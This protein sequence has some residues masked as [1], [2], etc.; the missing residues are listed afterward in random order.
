MK[1]SIKRSAKTLALLLAAAWLFLTLMGCGRAASASDEPQEEPSAASV[2]GPSAAPSAAAALPARSPGPEDTDASF[3]AALATAIR[4]NGESAAI[5]GPGASASGRV[6]TISAAGT[7]LLSGSL[8]DGQIVVDAG[9]EALVRLVLNGAEITNKSGAPIYAKG[10]K[11]L[12]LTLAEGTKNALTDG[13]AN[14]IYEN[15]D[16]EEPNAALFSKGDLSINGLGSLT[17]DAGFQNGVVSKDALL[18]ASGV[19]E[20]NALKH[21][22]RGNDSVEILGGE[23]AVQAGA[24]AIQTNNTADAEMGWLLIEGG[25]FELSAGNDGLQ[26][27]RALTIGGGSFRI[28]S[29]GAGQA[30]GGSS[31]ES[32]S[33]K[34]IKSGGDLVILGGSFEIDSQ[35]DALHTN[36]SAEISGGELSLRSG[37]DGIHADGDLRISG[38]SVTVLESYEGLEGSNVYISGGEISVVSSDDGINAAG[39][40]DGSGLGGR[41]GRDA[42][43]PGGA[44]GDHLL[45]ISGGAVRVQTRSDGLDSNGSIEI[46]G[47]L[48]ISEALPERDGDALD[49]GG[50]VKFTGGTIIYAGTLSTGVN[51]GADS[52]QSYVYASA[53]IAAGSE[54]SVRKDGKTLLAYTPSAS[55]RVMAF[56]CPEI[57]AG[58]SYEI[59]H[60]ETPLAT[61]TA[62]EG[63]GGM[64]GGQGGRGGAFPGGGAPEGGFPGG[65]QRPGRS[66]DGGAAP[67]SGGATP[68]A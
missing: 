55:I 11:K 27:D 68:V 3:D 54:I 14:F 7:Y 60:S 41:F 22:I 21:G 65:G 2:A 19:F 48:L 31:G 51:P 26:A 58:E 61:A 24:D 32:S 66:S 17:I 12:L 13:G 44:G 40:N 15:E 4:L 46:S 43:A 9:K 64:F 37:D 53:E 38:G 50:T 29:G 28:A 56:S 5:D 25:S 62:G 6:V 20:I 34:G 67:P 8:A 33:Q 39:G 30:A 47:G 23:F 52:S 42:F 1:R 49:A 18:I 59:Y 45:S 35:D 63:G 16:E 36:A 10:C 57:Q